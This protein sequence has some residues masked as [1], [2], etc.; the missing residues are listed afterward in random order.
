V[1]VVSIFHSWTRPV[2]K[3]KVGKTQIGKPEGKSL[4]RKS[5][6]KSASGNLDARQ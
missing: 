1:T 6:K 3:K 5:R 2:G 4:P